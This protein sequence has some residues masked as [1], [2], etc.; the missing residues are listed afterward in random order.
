MA[1]SA[2][3]VLVQGPIF[4]D[5]NGNR[6]AS[7]VMLRQYRVRNIFQTSNVIV[8]VGNVFNDTVFEFSEGEDLGTLWPSECLHALIMSLPPLA[9]HTHTHTHTIHFL[10]TSPH[11]P[12]PSDGIPPDGTPVDV[13]SGRALALSVVLLLLSVA[14]IAF[15]MFCLLFNIVFRQ[16]K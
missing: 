3:H 14:G 9:L 4:F 6:A 2:L 15:T 13:I 1:C 5:E 11:I 7:Q 16:R 10:Y 12:A 8:T